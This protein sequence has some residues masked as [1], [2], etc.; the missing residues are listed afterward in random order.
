MAAAVAH[1]APPSPSPRDHVPVATARQRRAAV[2]GD[3]G[4]RRR[5]RNRAEAAAGARAATA[6]PPPPPVNGERTFWFA[7]LIVNTEHETRPVLR[8]TTKPWQLLSAMNGGGAATGESRGKKLAPVVNKAVPGAAAPP[9]SPPP[10]PPPARHHRDFDDVTAAFEFTID[11]RWP[12]GNAA[13]RSLAITG[14]TAASRTATLPGAPRTNGCPALQTGSDGEQSSGG[15]LGAAATAAAADTARGGTG[16]VSSSHAP[17][18]E[19]GRDGGGTASAATAPAPAWYQLR[20]R[21]RI[22]QINGPFYS[23][24]AV[25][26]YINIWSSGNRGTISKAARGEVLARQFHRHSYGDLATIFFNERTHDY[27]TT[28]RR[29]TT[30][31]GGARGDGGGPATVPPAPPPLRP[32]RKK[33]QAADD[34]DCAE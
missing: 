21:Y 28:A 26:T 17:A 24:S 25:D 23:E 11:T 3:A 7:V 14:S 30:V 32:R 20:Q 8:K 6:S 31:S 1:H 27:V 10:A 5:R 19:D 4:T 15:A 12:Q 13:I 9:P 22:G 18:S 16:G 34:A 29:T 33:R 2:H